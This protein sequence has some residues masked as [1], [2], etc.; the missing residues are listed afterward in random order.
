MTRPGDSGATY[1]F[2]YNYITENVMSYTDGLG[3][4]VDYD[5]NLAWDRVTQLKVTLP[6]APGPYYQVKYH[7][8]RIRPEKCVLFFS[9]R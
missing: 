1:E 7:Y 9:G 2:D 8:D 6:D 3:Y 5:H 4:R